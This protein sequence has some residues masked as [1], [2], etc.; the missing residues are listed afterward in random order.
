MMIVTGGAGFIGSNIAAALEERGVEVVICDHL[1][2]NDKWRNLAKRELAGFVY[3]EE[4]L[5]FLNTRAEAI[6]AIVHMG[7]AADGRRGFRDTYSDH[8]PVTTCI[9]LKADDD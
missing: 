8:Y 3:P 1:R 6:E 7:L 9:D 5:P 4:L 2:A